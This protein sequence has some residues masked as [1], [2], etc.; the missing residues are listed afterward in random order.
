MTAL[1]ALIVDDELLA[2]Q[3]LRRFLAELPDVTVA[4]ECESGAAAIAAIDEG[5]ADVVFLDVQMPNVDGFGVI[6]ALGVERMP[7]VV[8]VT[9]HSDYA[10]RAFRAHAVDYLLKPLDPAQVAEALQRVRARTLRA[11]AG[12][13]ELIAERAA[14]DQFMRRFIVRREGRL[15]VVPVE[16]VDWIEAADNDIVLHAGAEAHRTRA[17]L[18]SVADRLDPARFARVHRSAVVNLERV[19]EIQPWFRGESVA[20]LHDGTRLTIGRAFRESFVRSLGG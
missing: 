18:S 6:E 5:N 1:R 17:T 20:I 7:P 19:R 2:R 8:F 9:A 11:D 4:G 13:R 14:A 12:L 15:Q 3:Q 16:R 10:L